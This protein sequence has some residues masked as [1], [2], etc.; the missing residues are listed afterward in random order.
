M[1]FTRRVDFERNLKQLLTLLSSGQVAKRTK[2]PVSILIM[3]EMRG[4]LN[5]VVAELHYLL[6]FREFQQT[7]HG[8]SCSFPF[9][10]DNTY[11]NVLKGL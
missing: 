5:P 8:E 7:K 6:S 9:L 11:V 1:Y 2:T 4:D 10:Q 3:S